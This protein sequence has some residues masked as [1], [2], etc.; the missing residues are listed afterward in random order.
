MEKKNWARNKKQ[1][2][3]KKKEK[4]EEESKNNEKKKQKEDSKLAHYLSFSDRREYIFPFPTTC[5]F[6]FSLLNFSKESFSDYFFCLKSI[7]PSAIKKNTSMIF[8]LKFMF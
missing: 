4:E 6:A 5:S 8:S 2:Q 1:I 7:V 3:K